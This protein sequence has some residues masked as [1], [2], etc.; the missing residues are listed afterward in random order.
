MPESEMR[1]SR[2]GCTSMAVLLVVFEAVKA[3]QLKV[4]G[5]LELLIYSNTIVERTLKATFEKNSRK[6]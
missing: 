3:E 4:V 6:P 1:L 2:K 5:F